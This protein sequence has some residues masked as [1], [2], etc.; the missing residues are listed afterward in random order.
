MNF[1]VSIPLE[2]GNVFRQYLC[3]NFDGIVLSQSLWNRAMSFDLVIKGITSITDQSQSLWNRAMSFDDEAKFVSCGALKS[4][5]LWNRAMSFD[6]PNIMQ[7]R[8][9]RVSIP[10]EQGNVFRQKT[11]KLHGTDKKVSIPLEQGNVFRPKLPLWCK[12]QNVSIPLE[13]GNVFRLYTPFYYVAD[14]S[15]NPFGTGQCLSTAVGC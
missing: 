10:L 7:E 12:F 13:Q 6:K 14:A 15:L 1:H 5:S 11:V 4:Q 3:V 8:Y 2:Q 9:L